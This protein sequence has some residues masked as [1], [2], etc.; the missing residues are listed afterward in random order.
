MKTLLVTNDF[1]PKVGGIQSYLFGLVSSLDPS[2]VRVLA[3]SYPGDAAFDAARPFEVV[4]ERTSRLYPTPGLLRRICG[5]AEGTDVVQFGYALQSWLLAPAMRRRT[6]VPYVV[7]VHGAEVLWPIRAPGAAR[8]LAWG[9]LDEAAAVLTVSEHTASSVERLTGGRVRCSVLRPIV[10]LERFRPSSRSRGEI[11]RR[12]G[13][14]ERPVVLC[15]SRL[16]PRK[17]QDRLVDTLPTLS[18]RFG[19]RLILVG[20]GALEGALRGRA[21]RRGVEGEVVF[22]GGVPDELLPAYYAA[23]DVF[24]MPVRSR[25]LGLEEEG[26]GVVYLEAAA[27]GLPMV[28]GAS[29]GA[30]EAVVDGETGYLVDG[31]STS[32][33]G[34]ALARLL[35]DGRLRKRMGDAA[36]VRA[37][38]LH[39][40]SSVGRRYRG[41]L[42]EAS[43]G[44]GRTD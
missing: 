36:R 6:G 29:G 35:G 15:V 19:A 32:E 33:I 39:G 21:R 13:L 20:E 42:E 23:A 40:A 16:T 4:R 1:P 38:V 9:T 26:F 27:A 30:V 25:W 5:L 44:R 14:G 7:F 10:D 12:H 31:R 37:S 3:P 28:V 8:L 34:A 11:R 17:G 22:A 18:R 2:E 43:G 41:L 24:A